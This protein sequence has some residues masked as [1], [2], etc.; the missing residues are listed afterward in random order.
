[1][2]TKLKQLLM[3]EY[4]SLN[5]DDPYIVLMFGGSVGQINSYK[6]KGYKYY[7]SGKGWGIIQATFKDLQDAKIYAKH[8][9]S[10]LSRGQKGYYKIRYNVI[11]NNPK[12]WVKM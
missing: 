9:N 12:K 6:G 8:Q 1:M 7:V 2:M 10:L 5:I 11:P 4:N 3:E